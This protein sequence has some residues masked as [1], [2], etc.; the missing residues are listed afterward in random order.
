MDKFY[1]PTW[2]ARS[3]C[4]LFSLSPGARVFDPTMGAGALLHAAADSASP[5]EIE[6]L[7]CDIDRRTVRAVQSEHPAWLVG[8]A[9]IFSANSRKQ[10]PV[11]ST[12]ARSGVD[13]VVMNPPFSFRGNRRKTVAAFGESFLLTP[14]VASLAIVL[15][16]VEIKQGIGIILPAGSIETETN[17]SFWE[18]IGRS[19][20]VDVAQELPRGSFPDAHASSLLLTIRKRTA[21]AADLEGLPSSINITSHFPAPAVCKCVEVVRGRVPTMRRL[22]SGISSSPFVH[23]TNLRGGRLHLSDERRSSSVLATEG[24][25]LLLPRVGKFYFEKLVVADAQPVVLSDC[26]IALRTAHPSQLGALKSILTHPATGLDRTYGGTGA[27][28]T[29]VRRIMEKLTS[30]GF[31]PRHVPASGT[32]FTCDCLFSQSVSTAS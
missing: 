28:Y 26:V 19:Y 11:W 17:V 24:P 31:V 1:S 27:P 25:M 12:A 21:T 22:E 2:L 30:I 32:P 8:R 7:G 10:S 18:A 16:N 15:E 4:E 14:A 29:T 23:T 3:L 13:V 9:D 5:N 20:K 6:L